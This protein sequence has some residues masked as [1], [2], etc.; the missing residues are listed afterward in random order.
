ARKAVEGKGD[1]TG[2][3]TAGRYAGSAVSGGVAGAQTGSAAG[4]VGALPGAAAGAVKGVAAEG[5]KDAVKG[6]GK[7]TGGGPSAKPADKRGLGA[8]G[9]SYERSTKNKNKSST[10]KK[11]ATGMAVAGGAAAAPPAAL[12]L[13][14]M[15]L[16]KWLKTLFFQMAALAANL[17]AMALNWLVGMGKAAL[18]V[19]TAPFVALGGWIS[20]GVT[21]VVGI[22]LAPAVAVGSGVMASLAA[23]SVLGGRFVAGVGQLWGGGEAPVSASRCVSPAVVAAAGRRDTAADT[24]VSLLP[25]AAT[26]AGLS[27]PP[28]SPTPRR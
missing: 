28:R 13:T 20:A 7:A 16:F 24:D 27:N 25:A 12:M 22:T 19:I 2:R 6:V 21:A 18:G 9:T 8:G 26:T 15:A 4:G 10:G 5:G 23:F 17:W 11:V 3:R 14:L 1:S